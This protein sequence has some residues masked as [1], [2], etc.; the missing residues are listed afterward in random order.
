MMSI[1]PA[2]LSDLVDVRFADM[3]TVKEVL[4]GYRELCGHPVWF[5]YLGMLYD[6]EWRKRGFRDAPRWLWL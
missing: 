4:T 5:V 2:S 6:Q 3:Q 1:R